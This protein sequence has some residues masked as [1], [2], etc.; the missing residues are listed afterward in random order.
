MKK[1]IVLLFVFMYNLSFSQTTF[2]YDVMGNRISKTN[3]G[4]PSMGSLVGSATVS[5]NQ[6]VAYSLSNPS[7]TYVYTWEVGNGTFV[8][9]SSSNPTSINWN[10]NVLP[11]F[12]KLTVSENGCKNSKTLPIAVSGAAPCASSSLALSNPTHNQSSGNSILRA[13]L[14]IAATNKITGG[15][16]GY[17]SGKTVVLNP[18][19][20]AKGNTVFKAEIKGCN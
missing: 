12:I 3:A 7:N 8:G 17:E 18:G 14:N 11:N 19:F 5:L 4:N 20:E 6:T 13:G 2:Q 10:I 1:L 15:Q 16:M 9:G